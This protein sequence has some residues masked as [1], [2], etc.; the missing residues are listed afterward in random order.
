MPVHVTKLLKFLGRPVLSVF[1]R[2]KDAEEKYNEITNIWDEYLALDQKTLQESSD[3]VQSGT[4]TGP[5]SLACPNLT[6][7]QK[8]PQAICILRSALV[9]STGSIVNPPSGHLQRIAPR[10]K[11]AF[12]IRKPRYMA[13]VDIEVLH[14][15]ELHFI[16]K[17]CRTRIAKYAESLVSC[18]MCSKLRLSVPSP[19][20]QRSLYS[21]RPHQLSHFSSH[22]NV[23]LSPE[24]EL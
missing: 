24:D 22:G 2:D 18:A 6:M 14:N 11:A 20:R 15:A 12:S 19:Q 8:S 16:G 7:V 4:T 1:L 9:A 3:E 10:F 17:A 5:C 13:S 21:H 23:A